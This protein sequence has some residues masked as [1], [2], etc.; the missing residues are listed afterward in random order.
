MT[1]L[2]PVTIPKTPSPHTAPWGL[3]CPHTNLRGGTI[4]Y[5]GK[6]R[7]IPAPR[8]VRNKAPGPER[9]ITN[10]GHLPLSLEAGSLTSRCRRRCLPLRALGDDPSCLPS[11]C[12]AG[13]PRC[14][15]APAYIAPFPASDFPR[16][17]PCVSASQCPSDYEDIVLDL[18][19]T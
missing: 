12:A 3:G 19:P 10:R 5:K 13:S 1:S 11:L 9:L 17:L 2:N 16:L 18:G 7:E 4:E 14:P 6:I 15:S 8:N